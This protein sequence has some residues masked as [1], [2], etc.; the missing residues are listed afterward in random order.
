MSM[1]PGGF[2]DGRGSAATKGVRFDFHMIGLVILALMVIEIGVASTV[3][4][5]GGTLEVWGP[6]KEGEFRLQSCNNARVLWLSLAE[7]EDL[8]IRPPPEPPP[9]SDRE[10]KIWWKM[11]FPERVR[12]FYQLFHFLWV[13]FCVF[14]ICIGMFFIS[15]FSFRPRIM[16]D[17]SAR[18]Y[19]VI[20]IEIASEC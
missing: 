20:R 14:L 6:S 7:E 5:P 18:Y 15:F 12:S 17:N 8:L 19:I 1:A 13:S 11:K 3:F 16:R 10:A 9:W 2:G 4:D